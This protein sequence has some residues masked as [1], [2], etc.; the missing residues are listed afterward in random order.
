MQS[1]SVFFDIAKST[2]FR[3]KNA[4]FSRTRG[5]CHVIHIFFRSCLV[6]TVP[7]FIIKEYMWQ[8]LGKGA[9]LHSPLPH[10]WAALQ[11]SPNLPTTQRHVFRALSN[12]LLRVVCEISKRLK[13]VIYFR[14]TL[15]LR[16]LTRFWIRTL[17]PKI[18]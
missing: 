8:I 13:P 4:D 17:N 10:P 3:W 6:I 7:S 14:K 12:I 16:C 2:D 15:H 1:I 11:T 18:F 9:F 5:V